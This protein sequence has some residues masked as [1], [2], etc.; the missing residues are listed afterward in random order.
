MAKGT[1]RGTLHTSRVAFHISTHEKVNAYA[2]DRNVS[3]AEAVRRL[4]ERGCDAI[5][6]DAYCVKG[7]K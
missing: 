4:V 7:A 3:Y 5:N 2:R 1:V 6:V